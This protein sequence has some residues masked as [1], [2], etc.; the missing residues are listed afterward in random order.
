MNVYIYIYAHTHSSDEDFKL[1]HISALAAEE[2]LGSLGPSVWW[3][4]IAIIIDGIGPQR[5]VSIFT[6]II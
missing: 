3:S 1:R 2:N 6:N 4:G 5:K